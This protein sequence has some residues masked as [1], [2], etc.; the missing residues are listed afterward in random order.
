MFAARRHRSSLSLLRDLFVKKTRHAHPGPLN[1][2][3]HTSTLPANSY[4]MIFLAHPQHLTPT[5]SYSSKNRGRGVA[6]SE[7]GKCA[8]RTKT[9]NL[10]RLIS[11]LHNFWIPPV[12]GLRPQTKSAGPIS[13][14]VFRL[15][16]FSR[17]PVQRHRPVHRMDYRRTR[18]P[19]FQ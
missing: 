19:R 14:F 17:P 16:A 13:I 4:R 15:S 2:S 7:A 9:R 12:G 6:S 8:T 11:L 5:E 1:R 10:N 3:G 18:S